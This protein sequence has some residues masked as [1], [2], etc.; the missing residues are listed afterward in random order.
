MS[1]LVGEGRA[2]LAS[3]VHP[4]PEEDT[5]RSQESIDKYEPEG[6]NRGEA[7]LGDTS[8]EGECLKP[9]V[10]KKRDQEGDETIP[11][12]LGGHTETLQEGMDGEGN[13][14]HK[15]LG[16]GR[17]RINTVHVTAS[18]N[19]IFVARTVLF[20]TLKGKI[21]VVLGVIMVM[22]TSVAMFV[23]VFVMGVVIVELL[24]SRSRMGVVAVGV[25][26]EETVDGKE[27]EEGDTG[28]KGSPSKAVAVSVIVVRVGVC[29]SVVIMVMVM[30]LG[31]LLGLLLSSVL[32]VLVVVL[33]IIMLMLKGQVWKGSDKLGS[34]TLSNTVRMSRTSLHHLRDHMHQH[35]TQHNTTSKAVAVRHDETC[36][37]DSALN[38]K[39]QVAEEHGDEEE[40]TGADELGEE[41]GYS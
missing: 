22:R 10:G 21:L 9:L 17:G 35:G 25:G 40:G 32:V 3:R 15:C 7:G 24:G 1:K 2:S 11:G 16:L 6:V 12:S 19:I 4:H 18:D 23:L 34:S 8:T 33:M 5:S 39:W 36:L 41:E 20:I 14:E 37:A 13:D 26:Q 28:R 38:N 30:I 31:S 27:D 29:M